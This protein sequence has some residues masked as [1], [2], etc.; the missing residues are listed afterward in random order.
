VNFFK[1]PAFTILEALIAMSVMALVLVLLLQIV[2]GTAKLWRE[3]ESVADAYRE[4]RAAFGVISRDLD[5]LVPTTNPTHFLTGTDAF[6]RVAGVAGAGTNS[7]LFFLTALPA[8]AQD[9]RSNRSEICQVG[10]FTAFEKPPGTSNSASGGLN[11][12]RYLLSGDP[13]FAR[14]TN[15][16]GPLFPGDLSAADPR[17]EVLAR[18]VTG[19]TLRSFIAANGT[20][21]GFTP[22]PAT[23]L[24]DLVEITVAA[25]GRDA[26]KKLGGSQ[27]AWTDPNS[28]V[29]RA[30]AQTFSTRVNVNRAR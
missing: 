10:Y 29:I 6:A 1:S 2:G 24:P 7:T 15:P 23:P 16:A 22:S 8:S 21:T 27:S 14:L 4:A 12:Y 28:P 30:A 25:V 26:A 9:S 18:N 19:F 3:N 11:I 20:L 5:G 13:A 17:V